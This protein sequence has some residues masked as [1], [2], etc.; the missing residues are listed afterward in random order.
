[1]GLIFVAAQRIGTQGL[2]A[3]K[4]Y[5]GPAAIALFTLLLNIGLSLALL[6]PLGT[7]GL[8]LSN[9]L[10]SLAGLALLLLR[11]RPRLPG[12][13]LGPAF[14]QGLKAALAAALMGVLAWQGARW[15][16]LDLPMAR[17][18]LALRLLPLIAGCGLVYGALAWLLGHPE[19]KA[20][21]ARIGL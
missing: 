18:A 13:S 10:A 16:G 19:A 8:A 12:L 1:V 15:L 2:Y 11:L 3:L 6:K 14:S 17:A 9:G 20:L 5:R 4:D 7:G 21:G